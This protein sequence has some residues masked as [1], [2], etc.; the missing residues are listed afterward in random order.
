M[1]ASAEDFR[2]DFVAP[3]G[4]LRRLVDALEACFFVAGEDL[5]FEAIHPGYE[6]WPH[7]L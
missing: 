6:R 3:F 4:A 5:D 2:V 1:V 7:S